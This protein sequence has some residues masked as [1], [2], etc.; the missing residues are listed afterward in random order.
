MK[1]LFSSLP[2]HGH[3]YPLLPLAIAAKAAGHEITYATWETFHPALAALGFETIKAGGDMTGS[4]TEVIAGREIKDLTP[5]EMSGIAMRVFGDILPRA[6]IADLDAVFERRRFDLV[7]HEA[8]AIGAAI[9]AKRAGI[10]SVGHGVSK[11]VALDTMPAL[12]NRLPTLAAE[13]GVEFDE[14]VGF[15]VP[16][17]DIYPE[18]LQEP[19]QFAPNRV[20]LRPVAFAEPGELPSIATSGEG[21]L[22]YLTLGTAFGNPQVLRAAIDGLAATGNRVVVATGPTVEVAALGEPPANVTV[23]PWVAQ[24]ELLPHVDLVVHHGGSGTTLGSAAAGVKQLFIP[25]GADQ[26]TNA[27]TFTNAGAARQLLGA[28]VTPEALTEAA[29]ELLADDGVTKVVAT[30]AEEIAAMPG[31]EEIAKRLPEWA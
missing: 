29:T 25:Q 5:E 30:L 8:A 14:R 20:P 13:F 23:L 19:E 26:F 28:D 17:L 9:A 31:P 1:I 7:V 2:A 4:F 21:R 22:I 6:A 3:T 15:G 16:Y 18:S 27:E 12:K 24:A 10:P 11:P